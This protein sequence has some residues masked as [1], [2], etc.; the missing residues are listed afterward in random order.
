MKMAITEN[1]GTA[2]AVKELGVK[3]K[4]YYIYSFS[5]LIN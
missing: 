2:T 1:C 3:V 5:S 4:G